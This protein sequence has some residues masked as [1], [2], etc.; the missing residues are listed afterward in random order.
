MQYF[1][2]FLAKLIP[3]DIVIVLGANGNN[4]PSNFAAEKIFVEKMINS[5]SAKRQDLRFG[6]IMYSDDARIVFKLDDEL[7]SQLATAAVRRLQR[8]RRG[9]NIEAALKL[10]SSELVYDKNDARRNATK[11][12]I[13]L[14]DKANVKDESLHESARKLKNH[15][16]KI[17]VVAIGS[18]VAPKAI[19]DIPS[20]EQSLVRINNLA[21]ESDKAISLVDSQI[22]QGKTLTSLILFST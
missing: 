19:A 2:H 20:D 15:G 10:A 11:N 17:I 6:A 18:D 21:K 4:A 5:Y 22:S 1:F 16:I 8:K 13:I 12:L 7:N 14:M 9:N 3:S